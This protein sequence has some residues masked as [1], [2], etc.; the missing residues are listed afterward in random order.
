MS[1]K[2]F[3]KLLCSNYRLYYRTHELNDILYLHFKS[4][5]KIEN[6]ETFTNLKVLYLEGNS[7][8]KIEGLN[9]LKGLTSLYLHENCIEKIEN[10]DGLE[11]LYNLNLSDNCI[12][13]IENLSSLKNLSNLLL[14]RNRIGTNDA[15]DL[16]GLSELPEKVTV[17]DISNNRI[18]VTEI[19]QDFLTK[20]KNLR[21]LY[22]QGNECVRKIS[23]YRKT[24]INTLKNLHYLDDKPVFED[25]RRFAEAFGRGGL[26]EER[27][28]RALYRKE[29]E[30]YE[31][32]RLKD[33]QDLID[34]WKRE[35][36]DENKENIQKSDDIVT[37]LEDNKETEEERKK[38]R[39]EEKIKLLMKCKE[40]QIQKNNLDQNNNETCS[41]KNQS[42]D[43]ILSISEENIDEDNLSNSPYDTP[44]EVVKP[45]TIK[46]SN[47][48]FDDNELEENDSMPNLENIKFKKQ[49][50]FIDY[51]L[52][53]NQY[54]EEKQ[55]DDETPNNTKKDNSRD[56]SNPENDISQP[57]E[58]EELV[59]T[60]MD[61]KQEPKIEI[62]EQNFDELD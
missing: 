38:K 18:E 46:P 3:N 53:K 16:I 22:I 6:L 36:Q 58:K 23:H 54:E 56:L 49:A 31:N 43:K 59:D 28:E 37:A 30:E 19:V 24:L 61:H 50:E 35:K 12:N 42:R 57:Q 45:K 8:K 13:K 15:D 27:R 4:F 39:E 2:F 10:L 25:E 29:K 55:M 40:K 52:E 5:K 41:D 14:K 7:I 26:D 47:D 34:K 62:S 60:T 32:K 11:N 21:V 51:V 1:K 48:I 20:I 33:F 44:Q 17:L 9:N